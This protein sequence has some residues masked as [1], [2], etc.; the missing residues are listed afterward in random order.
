MP[1]VLTT[2]DLQDIRDAFTETMPSLCTIKRMGTDQDGLSTGEYET[3]VEGV[4]CQVRLGGGGASPY[5]YTGRSK[6]TAAN[7]QPRQV[8]LV[9]FDGLQAGDHVT[10]TDN[11]AGGS[12]DTTYEVLNAPQDQ[13]YLFV[14]T[15]DAA[16]TAVG[17]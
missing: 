1:G 5:V 9:Y 17:G 15:A 6:S 3:I 10:V 2:A 11:T 16:Q 7:V 13:A 12:A 4:P 14:V 8:D